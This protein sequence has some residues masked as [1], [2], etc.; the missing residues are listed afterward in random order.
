MIANKFPLKR[1]LNQSVNTFLRP[2]TG[3]LI[4]FFTSSRSSISSAVL[5]RRQRRIRGKRRAT[6]L[7]CRLLNPIPS[8]AISKTNSAFTVRTGPNFSME[9]LVT[10]RL[11]SIISLSVSPEYALAIVTNVSPFFLSLIHISE[12]T[13]PY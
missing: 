7:L 1:T 12:P 10:K 2:I 9:F 5:S 11:T 8:K 13:R 3:Y 4:S 6:P